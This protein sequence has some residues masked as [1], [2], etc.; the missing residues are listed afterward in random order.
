[1]EFTVHVSVKSEI[2]PVLCISH[3]INSK[4]CHMKYLNVDD[5]YILKYR[6]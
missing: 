6:Y 3:E 1:M 2:T 5:F 4:K